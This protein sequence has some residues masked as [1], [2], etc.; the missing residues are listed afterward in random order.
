[1]NSN[2]RNRAQYIRSQLEEALGIDSIKAK[3]HPNLPKGDDLKTRRYER[4]SSSKYT[5]GESSDAKMQRWHD[6]HAAKDWSG[7]YSR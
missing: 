2:N 4:S 6:K 5:P 3:V 1:M 7:V